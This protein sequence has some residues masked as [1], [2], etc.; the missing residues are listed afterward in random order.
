MSFQ[1]SSIRSMSDSSAGVMAVRRLRARA[2]M[3]QSVRRLAKPECISADTER[4]TA[5]AS[6]GCGQ[7]LP[8]SSATYSQMASESHRVSS[9]WRNI[10]TRSEERRVGKECR[11]GGAPYHEKKKKEEE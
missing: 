10:G 7:P 2:F 1:I 9:P 3:G 6:R 11:T 5:R 4:A 8:V